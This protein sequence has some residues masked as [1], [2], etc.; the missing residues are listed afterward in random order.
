MYTGL[1]QRFYL[2]CHV[3][4][5][6]RADVTWTRQHRHV[7]R[8]MPRVELVKREDTW[9]LFLNNVTSEDFGE[10]V[11]RANNTIGTASTNVIVV[12]NIFS[13][14]VNIFLTDNICFL[15][16]SPEPPQILRIRRIDPPSS[17]TTSGPLT[18]E[19]G[20]TG[21]SDYSVSWSTKSF[22]PLLGHRLLVKDVSS[23][24]EAQWDYEP[25][26]FV[27]AASNNMSAGITLYYI[28]QW[29]CSSL[30]LK[31]SLCYPNVDV[32]SWRCRAWLAETGGSWTSRW[33]RLPPAPRRSPPGSPTS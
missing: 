10:Y 30:T 8:R 15:L 20:E 18:G 25:L 9:F 24:G 31:Q 3:S 13:S 11:C 23:E 1:G 26:Y 6:P 2:A 27:E 14:S 12:G 33:P 7:S 22:S 29:Q 21:L 28:T 16:G 4:A 19:L 5:E 32:F 17:I